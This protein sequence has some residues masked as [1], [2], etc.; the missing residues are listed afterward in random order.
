MLWNWLQG[1]C[2]KIMGRD[3]RKVWRDTGNQLQLAEINFYF[4]PSLSYTR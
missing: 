1:K 2:P 3:E 4:V